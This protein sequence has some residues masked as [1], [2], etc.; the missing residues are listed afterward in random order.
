MVRNMLN[1][2]WLNKDQT[3][4]LKS[5]L[6]FAKKNTEQITDSAEDQEDTERTID[7]LLILILDDDDE[8]T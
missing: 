8:S 4:I 1:G 7:V 6:E 2:F 3:K 5:S